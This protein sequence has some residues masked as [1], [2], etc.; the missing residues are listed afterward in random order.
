MLKKLQLKLIISASLA[1]LIV[2][3]AIIGGINIR[4]YSQVNARAED[5]I[6]IISE[7]G[8]EFPVPPAKN[9]PNDA[10]PLKKDDKE[11]IKISPEAPFETRFF[12][13]TVTNSGEIVAVDL[14]SIAAITETEAK[15]IVSSLFSAG[16]TDGY[17]GDYKYSVTNTNDGNEI[18]ILLDCSRDLSNFRNF[19]KTSALIS[20]AGY[21]L[22]VVLVILFSGIVMKPVAETYRKQKQFITDANHELETPLTV[23]NASC[24]VMEMDGGETEWTTT[25]KQEVARLKELTDKLVFLSRMDEEDKKIIM[26]DFS[27]SEVAEDAIKPYFAEARADGKTL[28]AEIDENLTVKGE[29][30]MIKSLFSLLLDNAVKYSEDESEIRIKVKPAGKNCKIIV[31]NDTDGVQKGDLGIL[32]ERFYRTDKSRNSETGG[33]G[34]GLSVA[35]AIVEKHNGKITAFSE[36]GKKITFTAIV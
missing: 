20:L 13:V 14:S 3:A 35:K 2:L 27:L 29:P 21:A 33:H 34:I 17:Y 10:P 36:D 15:E 25:I 23:I 6:R 9:E 24:E 18:Y 26:T 7:N 32:F 12:T 5:T 31:E 22:A 28:K 4:N 8:G 1:I 19:L 30:S 11:P 16:K